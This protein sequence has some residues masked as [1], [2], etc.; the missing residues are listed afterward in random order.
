[1]AFD[2]SILYYIQDH[3]TSPF[4]DWIMPKITH[5]GD[6]GLIWIIFGLG[7]VLTKKYRIHGLVMLVAL[8]I[9]VLV[10]NIALKNI[11]ARARPCW[12]D[13]SV[14][15]LIPV[16]TDYSF[17]SGHTLASVIGATCIYLTNKKFALLAVPLAVL[18]AFSRLYLFVHFPT[19]IIAS[20][21][22]GI[23]IGKLSMTYLY[24]PID[25]LYNKF[26]YL[27]KKD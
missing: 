5:L 12:I 15:I 16:P 11:V 26:R 24:A 6:A 10:G 9:G 20:A 7:L 19:D 21:I 22:I 1:M 4:G 27:L 25:I 13:S 18:I 23:T 3:L 8:G 2:W 14:Q 17:P